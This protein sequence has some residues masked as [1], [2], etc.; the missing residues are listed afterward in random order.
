MNLDIMRRPLRVITMLKHERII[1]IFA[2]L[3]QVH[4][5]RR[6]LQYVEGEKS[7]W[8]MYIYIYIYI[9]FVGKGLKQFNVFGV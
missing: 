8:Y 2:F 1:F 9:S 6:H 7:K 5:L 3:Y 4:T